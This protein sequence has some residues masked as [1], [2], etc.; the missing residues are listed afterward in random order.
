LCSKCKSYFIASSHFRVAAAFRV[1]A[2]TFVF[3]HLP[4]LAQYS[5]ECNILFV[6]FYIPL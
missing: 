4:W 1:L 3:P 5:P 6:M 2:V